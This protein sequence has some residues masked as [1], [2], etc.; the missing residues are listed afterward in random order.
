M[1]LRHDITIQAALIAAALFFLSSNAIFAFTDPLKL[2]KGKIYRLSRPTIL[3]P[4]KDIPKTLDELKDTKKVPRE[5]TIKILKVV[6]QDDRIIYF[7]LAKNLK[8]DSIGKG[9]VASQHLV[10]QSLDKVSGKKSDANNHDAMR[11][12]RTV[13]GDKLR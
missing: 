9:W 5:G 1:R 6:T 10:G 2:E 4:N 11:L 3:Y 13:W 8:G 12:M 7:V